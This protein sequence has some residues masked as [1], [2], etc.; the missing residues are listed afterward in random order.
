M[1]YSYAIIIAVIVLGLAYFGI[2]QVQQANVLAIPEGMQKVIVYKSPQCGCCQNYTAYL[3]GLGFDVEVVNT[4][5][6]DAIKAK[7]GVPDE[8]KSCHTTVIGDYFVEGHVPGEGYQKLLSELPEIK[9][10][11]MG[12]MPAGSPGMPGAKT[13]AFKISSVSDAGTEFF[14]SI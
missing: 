3:D 6:M 2:K 11:G 7:Y 8:L 10:I 14:T 13:G 1:K 9:G 5:D 4:N 12:G